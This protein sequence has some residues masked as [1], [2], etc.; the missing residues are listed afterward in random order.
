MNRSF[1][2]L[3]TC[4]ALGAGVTVAGCRAEFNPKVLA[5]NPDALFSASLR[6]LQRRHYEDAARGF[7]EL[8]RDLPAR[9]PLLP[10]SYYYLGQ[11]QEKNDDYLLAA[12]SFSRIAE[13]FPDDSLADDAL[14]ASGRSFAKMWRK[15][16]LDATYGVQAQ[17][18]FENLI[19]LYPDSP[20]MPQANA[21][22]AR[23]D[24]MFAQKDLETGAHYL[25]RRAYDSAIIY[26]KDVVRLHP[27]APA[28]RQA[29]LRLLD[30]YRAIRYTADARDL[31][32]SMLKSYPNDREVRDQCGSASSAAASTPRT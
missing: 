13:A 12:Q 4:L 20:L 23:L 10:L 24:E 7:E 26:L 17:Q 28:A 11:A 19:S 22:L 31:C 16:Q 9:D 8:T 29:S 27:N 32:E 15:P 2:S 25:R 3:L 6:Q 30:A 21:A 18:T 14:L 1:R 5:S